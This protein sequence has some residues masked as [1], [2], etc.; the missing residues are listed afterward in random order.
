MEFK[1]YF[2]YKQALPG[3]SHS[4]YFWDLLIRR[5]IENKTNGA[6][7]LS[8]VSVVLQKQTDLD[9]EIHPSCP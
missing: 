3:N 9:R 2:P 6:A 4:L 1:E 8:A 7:D 5:K